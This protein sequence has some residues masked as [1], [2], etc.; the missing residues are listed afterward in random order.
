MDNNIFVHFNKTIDDYDV[1]A[2]K[3]VMKNSE[4][5]ETI[6]KAIPFLKDKQFKVLDL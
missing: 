6:L 4:L 2:D 3:V 5:H 1:V